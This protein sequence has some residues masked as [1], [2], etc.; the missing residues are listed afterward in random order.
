MLGKL[1]IFLLSAAL[2]SLQVQARSYG[3]HRS[4]FGSRYVR[5][6]TK[7]N[8]S[9]VAPHTRVPP[10]TR[11]AAKANSR[12]YTYKNYS[13][14]QPTGRDSRGRIHRSTAAKDAFKRQQPCPSTGRSSGAC[15]GYVIDHVKALECGGAD[16]PSNMQWQTVV[17]GKA[18]DKWEKNC[19]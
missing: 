14:H 4:S 7:R 9:Y 2:C 13:A 5:G 12:L 10:H 1:L 8:G 3:S 19:R 6:Y 16:A 11:S 18:K 17:N 15:P